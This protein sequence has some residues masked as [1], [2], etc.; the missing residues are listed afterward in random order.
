M[1]DRVNGR[2][3][4]HCACIYYMQFYLDNNNSSRQTGCDDVNQTRRSQTMQMASCQ[5]AWTC[6]CCCHVFASVAAAAARHHGQLRAVI[7]QRVRSPGSR[8]AVGSDGDDSR[9]RSAALICL[10][11]H[12]RLLFVYYFSDSRIELSA[13]DL[14]LSR[15]RE[16]VT[17]SCRD[18]N[19]NSAV[20]IRKIKLVRNMQEKINY[21]YFTLHKHS[22]VSWFIRLVTHYCI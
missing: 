15:P 13:G 6:L 10:G 5:S 8:R 9:L 1:H 20:Y 3:A 4:E 21:V 22:S 19:T 12:Y 14:E 11:I 17:S 7:S 2:L 18:G 16:L